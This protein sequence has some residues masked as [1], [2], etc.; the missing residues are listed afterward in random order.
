M[1]ARDT[2]AIFPFASY[3]DPPPEKAA[4]LFPGSSARSSS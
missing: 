1:T 2:Q 4:G 3:D